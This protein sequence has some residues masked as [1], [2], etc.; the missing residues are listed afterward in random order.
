MR[1]RNENLSGKKKKIKINCHSKMYGVQTEL[2]KFLKNLIE[3]AS[4]IRQA[5]VTYSLVE[6]IF[7]AAPRDLKEELTFPLNTRP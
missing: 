6:S 3:I 1:V 4:I 5:F 2:T 7:F